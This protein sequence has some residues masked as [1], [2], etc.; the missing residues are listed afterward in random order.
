MRVQGA[1]PLLVRVRVVM[2]C[3]A[4]PLEGAA[5]PLRFDAL[6]TEPAACWSAFSLSNGL[7]V[8]M[9]TSGADAMRVSVGWGLEASSAW[10]VSVEAVGG[11]GVA[12]AEPFVAL[13]G[14]VGLGDADGLA[15]VLEPAELVSPEDGSSPEEPHADSA[16][17]AV[18][19]VAASSG[20][21]CLWGPRGSGDEVV[22]GTVL[23]L[24]HI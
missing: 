16:S 3:P 2:V 4:A 7:A 19:A 18:R 11:A 13:G 9:P 15:D 23:S 14:V 6:H 22:M 8:G 21:E 5:E 17:R 12:D 20:R 10:V 1:E 24:I